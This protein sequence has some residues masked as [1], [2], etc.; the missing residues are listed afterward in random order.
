MTAWCPWAG[1]FSGRSATVTFLPD[2]G[3][4]P[5]QRGVTLNRVV[6]AWVAQHQHHQAKK[7]RP[8]RPAYRRPILT[9]TDSG[10]AFAVLAAHRQRGCA[11][12]VRQVNALRAP[13]PPSCPVRRGGSASSGELCRYAASFAFPAT[14]RI[15][16]AYCIFL[17]LHGHG[18]I[19]ACNMDAAGNVNEPA[20][21]GIVTGVLAVS[22]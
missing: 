8:P 6:G 9:K 21:R 17:R 4:R 11:G 18:F 22:C 19:A 3:D 12:V 15:R 7:P 2:V 1:C 20:A 16:C 14:S 5:W 10:R 13:A